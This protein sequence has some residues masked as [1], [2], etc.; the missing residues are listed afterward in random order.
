M[1]FLQGITYFAG[2][3]CPQIPPSSRSHSR[4]QV[5]VRVNGHRIEL[6]SCRSLRPG[7]GDAVVIAAKAS[8]YETMDRNCIFDGRYRFRL[9]SEVK[10]S[11]RRPT[12]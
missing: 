9:K 11:T 4:L 2:L 3:H 7:T 1:Y 8:M 6:R 12:T 10:R 5:G